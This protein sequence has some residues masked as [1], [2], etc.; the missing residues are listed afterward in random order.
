MAHDTAG[1]HVQECGCLPDYNVQTKV[2]TCCVEVIRARLH[3]GFSSAVDCAA[4]SAKGSS[5]NG[6]VY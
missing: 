2:G 1:F 6:F 5:Q 3:F 4:L